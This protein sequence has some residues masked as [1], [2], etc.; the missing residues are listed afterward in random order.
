MEKQEAVKK[1]QLSKYIIFTFA[2]LLSLSIG[3]VSVSAETTDMTETNGILREVKSGIESKI[4]A[5]QTYLATILSDISLKV[6]NMNLV[7]TDNEYPL[8][9]KMNELQELQVSQNQ[10]VNDIQ[11]DTDSMQ[12]MQ[13]M[14]LD[15][16]IVMYGEQNAQTDYIE[17]IKKASVSANEAVQ[18]IVSA[19]EADINNAE[20]MKGL[21]E[22]LEELNANL[23]MINTFIGYMYAFCIFLLVVII[24]VIVY[25]ILNKTLINNAFRGF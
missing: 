15:N 20:M 8:M 24:S 5:L 10:I 22:T 17:E 14:I 11:Y 16:L 21:N 1:N 25:R 3:T 23:D 12:N 18:K 6:D 7:L 2:L 4:D 13:A 9:N 19:N